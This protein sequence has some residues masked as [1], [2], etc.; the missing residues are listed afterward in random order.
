[1]SVRMPEAHMRSCT[2]LNDV[3]DYRPATHQ[4][5]ASRFTWRG[6]Q[7]HLHRAQAWP[8]AE[9]RLLGSPVTERVGSL[10]RPWCFEC[11]ACACVTLPCAEIC[12]AVAMRQVLRV[13]SCLVGV[14]FIALAQ[15]DTDRLG[16]LADRASCVHTF[17]LPA[18]RSFTSV[19]DIHVVAANQ[20]ACKSLRS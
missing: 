15:A 8:A 11:Q 17:A 1:M 4:V 2:A 20:E 12:T 10:N 5:S 19:R 6:D 7:H 14:A 16:G 13:A 3:D 9:I 18:F